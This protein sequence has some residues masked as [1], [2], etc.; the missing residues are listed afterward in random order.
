M[1]DTLYCIN[2]T[3]SKIEEKKGTNLSLTPIQDVILLGGNNEKWWIL[4]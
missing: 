2:C 3:K 4:K 1:F